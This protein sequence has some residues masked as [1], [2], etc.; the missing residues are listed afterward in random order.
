MPQLLQCRQSAFGGLAQEPG[1]HPRPPTG[2]AGAPKARL[3]FS[4][5]RQVV[6]VG[7]YVVGKIIFGPYVRKIQGCH[8][9]S[10][11]HP[12]FSPLPHRRRARTTRYVAVRHWPKGWRRK[13]SRMALERFVDGQKS[14]RWP[15]RRAFSQRPAPG[16]RHG[17]ASAPAFR[18]CRY[19][20]LAG[21][22]IAVSRSSYIV[23]SVSRCGARRASTQLCGHHPDVARL[24]VVYQF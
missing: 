3:A 8:A 16:L 11:P 17:L 4:G 23:T 15:R 18:E 19:R 20:R 22:L 14:A 13:D 24:R 2:P 9:S 1:R 12:R 10:N 6:S 21:R 5:C 7:P